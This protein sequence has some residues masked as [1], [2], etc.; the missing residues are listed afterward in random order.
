M[1][2][3]ELPFII[4]GIDL[5]VGLPHPPKF[6]PFSGVRFNSKHHAYNVGLPNQENLA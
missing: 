5:E 3:E 6:V 1:N 2:D 4:N